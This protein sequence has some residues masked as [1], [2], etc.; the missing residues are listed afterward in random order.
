MAAPLEPAALL[1]SWRDAPPSGAAAAVALPALEAQLRVRT[2]CV[3]LAPH[4]A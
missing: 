4:A 1:A 2:C 3:R